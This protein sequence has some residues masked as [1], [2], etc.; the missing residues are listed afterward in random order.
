M[1]TTTNYG[2]TKPTVGASEN[3]WGDSLNTDMDLIDTQMKASADVAAAA[4]PKAGGTM[5]GV[6]AGFESTGID[7]NA[8]STAVTIDSSGHAIIGAGITLGNGQTYAAANTLDDYEEGTWTGTPTFAA[9]AA[10]AVTFTGLYVKIGRQV[11]LTARWTLDK[12]TGSGAFTITGLPFT[13]GSSQGNYNGAAIGFIQRMG[14]AGFTVGATISPSASVLGFKLNDENSA[15][16]V[17][18]LIGSDISASTSG[19][20]FTITYQV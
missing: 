19:A 4:L 6:I 17:A 5:T 18:D 8:T 15:N 7:D 20:T 14:R 9:G 11:T 3:T 1:A 10:S 2:L 16:S 13:N 12:N